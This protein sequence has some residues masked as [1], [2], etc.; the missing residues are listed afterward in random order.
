MDS[1][2]IAAIIA[3]IFLLLTTGTSALTAWFSKR[4]S[5]T[6][7]LH[8]D[9]LVKRFNETA[10]VVFIEGEKASFDALTRLTLEEDMRVRVT[11]FNPRQI[12]RASRYFQSMVSKVSGSDFEGTNYGKLEKYYRLTALNSLENKN[13]LIEMIKKFLSLNTN[14][15]VLRITGDK[16]DFE[17]VVFDHTKTAAFCFHD[18]SKYSV[19]HSCLISRDE[20]LFTYFEKLYQKIWEEDILLEI[21]FSLG[22]EHVLQKLK[23]LEK[24]EP[25][26]ANHDLSKID[27]AVHEA[28]LKIQAFK[29]L[30]NAS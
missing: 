22:K 9:E 19:I 5:D 23:Y 15:L 8:S 11:R 18:L 17:L 2:I 14:N 20:S 16:N 26:I 21:D 13:S 25:I 27:S 4:T 7:K 24:L 28:N 12:Q 30:A 3:G 29:A 10:K 1:Q 6:I